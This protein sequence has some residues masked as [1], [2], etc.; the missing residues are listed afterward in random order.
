MAIAVSAA[1]IIFQKGGE[2]KLHKGDTIEVEL[3]RDTLWK[4]D[5]PLPCRAVR[6]KRIKRCVAIGIPGTLR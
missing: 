3:R 6:I 4:L 1:L 5:D 2:A